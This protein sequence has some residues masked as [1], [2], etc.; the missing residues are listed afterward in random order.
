MNGR[1]CRTG[2]S[3]GGVHEA[4]TGRVRDADMR[5][6]ART[7]KGFLAGKGA[8]DELIDDH[9]ITGGHVFAEGPAGGNAKDIGHGEHF[10]R[11]DIGAVVHRR[12]CLNVAASVA[13]QEHHLDPIER[14]CQQVIRRHPPWRFHRHPV[15]V[16]QS[17]DVVNARSADDP[18]F[19]LHDPP[20]C[21]LWLLCC[22][23]ER[24]SASPKPVPPSQHMGAERASGFTFR[25]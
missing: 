11:S 9:E 17:V 16:F 24:C 13:R 18:D 5:H 7:E 21:N 1:A 23:A 6:K 20:F 10:Q 2:G 22:P 14:A 19:C 4:G 15:A 3:F 12:W 8:V 25:R